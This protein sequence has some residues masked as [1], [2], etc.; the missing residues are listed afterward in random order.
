ME[1][2]CKVWV[3]FGEGFGGKVQGRVQ[4]L[5][6]IT[7]SI[8]TTI[9]HCNWRHFK[10][11]KTVRKGQYLMRHDCILTGSLGHN[12]SEMCN[13]I[14]AGNPGPVYSTKAYT[15]ISS[16]FA[17]WQSCTITYR[18]MEGILWPQ[19]SEKFSGYYLSIRDLSY[20][21]WSIFIILDT[22]PDALIKK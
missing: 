16:Y 13:A 18:I 3:G 7:I 14:C 11:F 4:G 1:L 9:M 5:L 19:L 10:E 21:T 6:V 22:S 20:F 17:E 2:S 15:I 12:T 8:M